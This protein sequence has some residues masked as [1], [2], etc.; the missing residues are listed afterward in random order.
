M[1][2][3]MLAFQIS[4]TDFQITKPDP[5]AKFSGDIA[6]TVNSDRAEELQRAV[7]CFLR[8]TVDVAKLKRVDRYGVDVVFT[9]F[10]RKLSPCR[11]PFSIPALTREELLQR[12][13]QWMSPVAD[14]FFHPTE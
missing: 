13:D 6:K 7:E 11:V 2:I 5:V 1:H 12:L 9:A 10:G 4:G 14:Y 3:L 8:S